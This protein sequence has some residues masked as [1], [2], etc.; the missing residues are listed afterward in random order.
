M[1]SAKAAATRYAKA[2]FGLAQEAGEVSQIAED[3]D[4]L[5]ALA[6]QNPELADVLL[7]PLYP[8]EQRRAVLRSVSEQL[9][10]ST[11][12]SNFCQF[13]I[14]QRRSH[15]LKTIR[16]EFQRLAEAAAGR[17]RGEVV[18]AAPL[19][20]TQ[21]DA[22]RDVLSARTGRS[23]ELDVTVDPALLG[24]VVARV[25]DLIFDGTLRSRLDGLRA[26]LIGRH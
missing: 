22:L 12:F 4:R 3:L 20:K 8:A 10:L 17:V 23:V 15:G 19:S 24:G 9:G 13:L 21:V 5:L 2:L 14:E 16:D 25:G 7:R 6:D 18:S 1:A 26:D 11:T